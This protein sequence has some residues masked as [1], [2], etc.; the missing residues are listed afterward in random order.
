MKRLFVGI[1]LPGDVKEKIAVFSHKVKETEG[2]FRFVSAE[3]LHITLSFWGDVE[4]GNISFVVEK[5]TSVL[6]HHG[7]VKIDAI[8][9]GVF[10]TAGR[11]NVVWVGLKN[12]ALTDLIK[13][14]NAT[15]SINA[16]HEEETPHVTIARVK[17]GKNKEK[18]RE[19]VER[20]KHFDFGTFVADRI[21]LYE[22]KLTSAGPV[23]HIVKEVGLVK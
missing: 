3:N 19:V 1:S 22:S 11:I 6:A 12:G 9:G 23:Y 18:I 5:L 10:P 17:S 14:I 2:E 8:G 7:T 13:K 20:F 21:T 4:E 15:L 16:G